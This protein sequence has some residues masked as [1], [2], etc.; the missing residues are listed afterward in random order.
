[1]SL[2]KLE[3]RIFVLRYIVSLVGSQTGEDLA[4][5]LLDISNR[6]YAD[7]R[8]TNKQRRELEMFMQQYNIII[9][10]LYDEI[11]SIEGLL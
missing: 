5:R 8:M 9:G 6:E 4:D 2:S 10:Q 3:A 11:K 1:M 7:D